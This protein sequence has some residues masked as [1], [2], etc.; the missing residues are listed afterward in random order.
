VIA[1]HE[2]GELGIDGVEALLEEADGL[3]EVGA[4]LECA[5]LRR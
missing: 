3:L 4:E 5:M 2:L 1:L